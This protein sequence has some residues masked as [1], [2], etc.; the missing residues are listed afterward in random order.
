[1]LVNIVCSIFH[2]NCVFKKAKNT[3]KYAI[4]IAIGIL[5]GKFVVTTSSYLIY[6]LRHK[7]STVKVPSS[8]CFTLTRILRRIVRARTNVHMDSNERLEYSRRREAAL[9]LRIQFVNCHTTKQNVCPDVLCGHRE[10]AFL[11]KVLNSRVTSARLYFSL[12]FIYAQHRTSCYSASLVLVYVIN[13]QWE[14]WNEVVTDWSGRQGSFS[15]NAGD[16]YLSIGTT[17]DFGQHMNI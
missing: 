6:G 9:D 15:V 16:G 10:C 17:F 5:R 1:M 11:A 3:P 14:R 13:I 8:D 4:G 7:N 2:G 12:R